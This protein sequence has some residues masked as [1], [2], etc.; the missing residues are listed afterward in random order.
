MTELA[1][2]PRGEPQ[3]RRQ[4]EAVRRAAILDAAVTVFGNATFHGAHTSAIARLAGVAE[5]TIFRYYPSKREL[6]LAALART[7]ERVSDAWLAIDRE[8]PDASRALAAL[9]AWY[10]QSLVTY[11]P[12][13]RLRQRAAAEVEDDAVREVLRNGYAHLVGIVAAVLRRGQQQGAFAAG[14]DVEGAAW[15]FIGAGHVLDLTISTEPD[16]EQRT[17]RVEN[18]IDA[19]R[20]LLYGSGGGDAVPSAR[21]DEPAGFPPREDTTP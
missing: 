21:E 15:L 20:W 5:G 11:A 3:S 6:Y 14:F 12:P 13:L 4:P 18:L 8:T 1:L 10:R 9:G 16:P 19:Y 17:V 7:T 2:R